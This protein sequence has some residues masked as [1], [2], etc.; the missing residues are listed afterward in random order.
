MS[1]V[2]N[3]LETP[4][5]TQA[6]VHCLSDGSRP[7]TLA[8]LG[9]NARQAGAWLERLAGRSGTVATLLTASH[10]CLATLFGALRCGMNLVSLPHP[11]RG[12]DAEEY[13][14][15]IGAMCAVTGATHLLCD[16]GLTTLLANGAAPVHPFSDW[17][18]AKRSAGTDAPGT[19]VAKPARECT[20][21]EIQ[22]E[23][24]A[25]LKAHL[26]SRGHQF[27]RDASLVDWYLAD[28]IEQR[29]DGTLVNH[30]PLLI[31]TAGSWANRPNAVTRVPNFFL[32]ADYVRTN[33]DIATRMADI[34]DF[35]AGPIIGG[36]K[37]IAGVGEELLDH[38][39]EVASGRIVPAAVRLGQDDFLPWKRGVSL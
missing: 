35:D 39:I 16:P 31:N 26:N 2:V 5:S 13:R 6:R 38:I 28:S 15:Q 22:A 34:I 1:L 37:T 24:W 33:T 9:R 17:S 36:K 18:A 19:F 4:L 25:Q 30:E 10:D 27:L 12:M 20:R 14:A 7:L 21:A 23:V 32:A 3:A 29:A 8:E 11:A